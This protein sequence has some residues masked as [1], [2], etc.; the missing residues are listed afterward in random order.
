MGFTDKL[1]NYR[2][3]L[4]LTKQ[5][6]ADLFKINVTTY[7]LISSSERKPSEK[8]LDSL[9]LA[10]QKPREF[11][12]N[13]TIETF[14]EYTNLLYLQERKNFSAVQLLVNLLIDN[15]TINLENIDDLYNEIYSKIILDAVKTDVSH[16]L[17]KKKYL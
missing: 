10:S 4:A 8:F 11:W 7:K 2:C 12:L 13:D 5:G 14:E 15:N 6:I 3:E 16:I 9:E 1:E 17:E